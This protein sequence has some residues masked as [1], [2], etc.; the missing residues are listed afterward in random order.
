MASVMAA[1]ISRFCWSVRPAYHW[2]LMLGMAVSSSLGRMLFGS[3]RVVEPPQVVGEARA[4]R[5]RLDDAVGAEA[6][7]EILAD[8]H[9]GVALAVEPAPR[10]V[11]TVE[12]DLDRLA[13]HAD[14]APP[15]GLALHDPAPPGGRESPAELA[16][17]APRP[18]PQPHP[19]HAPPTPPHAP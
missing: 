14:E 11:A 6:H 19:P 13:E 15:V 3:P 17:H 1:T 9:G 5:V 8:L 2:T 10:G 16:P 12:A 4:E 7:R 18:H